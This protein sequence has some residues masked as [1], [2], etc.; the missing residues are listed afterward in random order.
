MKKKDAILAL[1]ALSQETRL[2]IF[3]LLVRAA[4]Y[5]AGEGGLPVGHIAQELSLPGPT[6]SFH[7]KEMSHAGLVGGERRGR[8]IFYQAR[9]SALQ[10][11]AGFLLNDCCQGAV[12]ESKDDTK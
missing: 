1:S 12:L 9:I 5:E 11:L 10:D 3:R 8:S 7:L 4:S 2:D 6:L